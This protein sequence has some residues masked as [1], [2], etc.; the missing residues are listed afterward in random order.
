MSILKSSSLWGFLTI[1][2]GALYLLSEVVFVRDT[3]LVFDFAR[4]ETEIEGAL[5]A[6]GLGGLYFSRTGMMSSR[7]TQLWLPPAKTL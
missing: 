7:T 1:V 3:A 5:S 6:I 4:G 2:L